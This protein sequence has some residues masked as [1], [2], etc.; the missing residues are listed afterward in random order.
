[1]EKDTFFKQ[2]FDKHYET[3]CVYAAR[4]TRDMDDAEDVVQDTF[5]KWWEII[6]NKP[7]ASTRAY[8]YQMVK[9]A[10]I[11]RARARRNDTVNINVLIDDEESL[12]QPEA[13]NDSRVDILLEAIDALPEKAHRVFV[14][15]CVN[16]RKYK[17]VA[18]EMNVSVNTIKTQFSRSL[19]FLRERLGEVPRDR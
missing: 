5:V 1:M 11:D 9:N 17:E 8:L 15:I 3:L 12:F 7:S 4:F 16:K 13:E 18:S 14:A 19:K 2:V 6:G 10:C